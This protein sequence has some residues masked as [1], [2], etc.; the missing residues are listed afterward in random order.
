[1]AKV[2]KGQVNPTCYDETQE[3]GMLPIVAADSAY[4]GRG[5]KLTAVVVD[6][7]RAWFDEAALHGRTAI[8]Q[9]VQWVKS[10]EEV[11]NGRWVHP[12][13]V[14]IRPAA[15]GSFRYYGLVAVSMLIDEEKGVGWKSLPEHVNQ[16][17]KCMN[18]HVDL[19]ALDDQG[20]AAL[21]QALQQ[22][23]DVLENSSDEI[24][25][26]LGLQAPAAT[27]EA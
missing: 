20:R 12:V 17:S 19:S 18:G 3:S 22:Y 2:R 8:E 4:G 10:P 5:P 6:G 26:A 24:K 9:A 15:G 21:L 16:L 27:P 23:P 13:W 14:Y 25:Q 1:M 11:P 7:P